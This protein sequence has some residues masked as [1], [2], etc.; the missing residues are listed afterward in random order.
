MG[1]FHQH[2]WKSFQQSSYCLV[3]Q[4][5]TIMISQETSIST[6]MQN[7]CASPSLGDAPL[8][9]ETCPESQCPTSSIIKL[10]MHLNS[11]EW[12]SLADAHSAQLHTSLLTCLR[13]PFKSHGDGVTISS[14]TCKKLH[15]SCTFLLPPLHFALWTSSL[16]DQI[17]PLSKIHPASNQHHYL[18][19]ISRKILL[20][21]C[22]AC[23]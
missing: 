9:V 20:S 15:F 18:D 3:W 6:V 22:V 11:S 13:D 17:L 16:S 2:C 4:Q 21:S 1:K 12:F 14:G 5:V 19:I 10:S 8:V 23:A 7:V